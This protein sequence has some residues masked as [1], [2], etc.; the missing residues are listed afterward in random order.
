MKV[1]LSIIIVNYRSW[2][3]LKF[4]LKSILNQE[5]INLEVIVVDNFSNDNKITEFKKN[6]KWIK[7]IENKANLGFAKA[8]NIG[9][10]F[11]ISKWLL[12]LNPDTLLDTN[13]LSTLINFCNSN[14]EHKI[15]GIKQLNS[16]NKH[17]NSFGLFLNMFTINGFFRIFSRFFKGHTYRKMNSNLISYPEW[18]SGS[19]ILLRKNDFKKLNG[20]NENFWMYYEDMDLCKRAQKLNLKVSLLNNWKCIHFHGESS[21]KNKEIAIKTKTEVIKSSHIY[22]ST[23]FSR[24]ESSIIHF[25]MIF[26]KLIEFLILSLFSS[27]KRK[28]FKL[29]LLYW[30]KSVLTG[31]WIRKN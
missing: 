8:C 3:K 12:F 26:S 27:N 16:K 21:R 4:C 24:L 10:M 13:S 29:S 6:F 18:I 5:D 28:I 2:D 7:W 15:I 1:E 25:I 23:H 30:S 19:F 17:T 11:T 31:N 14:D 22:I 9:S 20:W